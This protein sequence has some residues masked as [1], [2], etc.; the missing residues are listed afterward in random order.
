MEAARDK[1]P[2]D[3]DY[4]SEGCQSSKIATNDGTGALAMLMDLEG[5][6]SDATDGGETH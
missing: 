2:T 1:Q 5:F 4:D 3:L 6:G